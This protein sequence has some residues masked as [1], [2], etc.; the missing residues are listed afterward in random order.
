MWVY[1]KPD[2]RIPIY[3][4]ADEV[5]PQAMAQA[6]SLA[7]LPFARHVA[8]MAD[9]HPGFGM[10]IG[11]VLAT[12]NEILPYGVGGDIGCGMCAFQVKV[13]AAALSKQLLAHLRLQVLAA[14]PVGN[15]SRSKVDSFVNE[16]NQSDL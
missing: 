11:G 10:P 12:K 13:D 6:K 4:W 8:L 14:V 15:L 1:Q 2:A 3:S 7:N 16:Y 9:A 5:E